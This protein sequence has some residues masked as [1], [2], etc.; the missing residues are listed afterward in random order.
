MEIRPFK[1]YLIILGLMAILSVALATTVNVRITNEAGIKVE[2]PTQAGH[3]QGR[4]VRFCLS[5]GCYKQSFE[6]EWKDRDVCPYCGGR[7]FKMSRSEKD[8]LPPDTDMLKKQYVNEEK[9]RSV[10]ASIVLS[11]KERASI[12]R[13]QVCLVGQGR[14]IVSSHVLEIPLEGRPPLKVMVLDLLTKQRDGNGDIATYPSYYAY[15]F[16]GKGR[17]TPYHVERMIRMA[18]DRI[19]FNT[20]HRWAYCSVSGYRDDIYLDEIKETIGLI[21]PFMIRK[22]AFPK[23]FS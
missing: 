4:E 18:T 14:E 2:M 5:S 12:H 17:E 11:G 20:S 7:R 6:D 19:F 10:F 9:Q 13:P 15:W 21:Y 16:V 23:Y 3:W 22:E 1:P 8:L